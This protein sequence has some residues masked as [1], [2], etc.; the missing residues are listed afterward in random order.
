MTNSN[1]R[2]YIINEL[3]RQ[4]KVET[5]QGL[6]KNGETSKIKLEAWEKLKTETIREIFYFI[7]ISQVF[8]N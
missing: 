1:Q 7:F 2:K 4:L 3:K 8:F 6:S 5:Y